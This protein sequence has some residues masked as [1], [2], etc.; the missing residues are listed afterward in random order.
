[1]NRMTW[2]IVGAV[3]AA[4][5]MLGCSSTAPTGRSYAEIRFSPA[6]LDFGA[7]PQGTSVTKEL[8]ITDSGSLALTLSATTVQG[9]VRH[10]FEVATIPSTIAAGTTVKVSV[11]YHATTAGQDGA[12]IDVV[13]NADNAPSARVQLAGQTT[14][15]PAK[16]GQDA[17]GSIP[18]GC[19]GTLECGNCSDG[20]VCLQNT[21]AA[22]TCT[23]GVKDGSETDVDCG[24]SQCPACAATKGCA[25]PSDCASGV[26]QDG[27]CQAPT[28]TD[29]VKNGD[30]TGVDCGGSC[31]KACPDGQGCQKN[32]DCTSGVCTSGICQAPT[33]TDGVKNGAETDVDCGGSACPPC[34]ATKACAKPSDCASG[35]CTN[36]I[37]QAPTCTDG[38]QNGDETGVDCG[39]SCPSPCVDGEGCMHNSDCV[40]GVCDNGKCQAP[41]CTDGVKNGA[42]TDVDCGGSKCPAC[43]AG[44]ACSKPSDCASG[45]CTNGICQAPT[46]TDGVKN[47]DETDTDCGGATCPACAATKGCAK[48]SDCASGVCTTGVC[49]AP[50]CTDGVENGDETGVDCGGSCPTPCADGGG[51]KQASDCASGVCTGGICQAPTCTDQVKNG[52]ETGVDCGG[53]CPA[54]PIGQGCQHGSDCTTASCVSNVCACTSDVQCGSGQVCTSTGQC[55]AACKTATDCT[56]S[57]DGQVCNSDTGHCTSTCSVDAD[58]GTGNYCEPSNGRCYAKCQTDADCPS[59]EACLTG[60]SVPPTL[61]N[62]C[63]FKCASD[64][65]CRPGERCGFDNPRFCEPGTNINLSTSNQDGL[66]L[67]ISPDTT[68]YVGGLTSAN[69]GV[70]DHFSPT[71]AL[72]SSGTLTASSSTNGVVGLALDSAGTVYT[73]DGFVLGTFDA[74]LSSAW[75][76][77][78]TVGVVGPEQI[79]F[80]PSGALDIA[81]SGNGLIKQVRWMGTHMVTATIGDGLDRP[82]QAVAVDAQRRLFIA[83]K[84]GAG[85]LNGTWG[86]AR[87]GAGFDASYASDPTMG[88][89]KSMVFD[90]AGD[91]FVTDEPDGV[92][93]KITPR[94][95]VI[96]FADGL[97]QPWGLAFDPVGRLWVTNFGK[98]VLTVFD[99]SQ[100]APPAILAISPTSGRPGDTLTI[101]GTNFDATAGAKNNTVVFWN[102]Y[103][104]VRVAAGSSAG[105]IKLPI[106]TGLVSDSSHPIH[107]AVVTPKGTGISAQTLTLTACVDDLL[108]NHC[109][110]ACDND[111]DCN[112]GQSCR[113]AD[114]SCQTTCTS[115]SCGSG[116]ACDST[117]GA[118]LAL[119]QTDADCPPLAHC[120][121]DGTC[122][123]Y[124]HVDTDCAVG[125][126]CQTTTGACTDRCATGADC[127]SGQTC[128]LA[129]GGV[130]VSALCATDADC[131]GASAGPKC[132]AATGQCGPAC[133]SASDCKQN[134][135]CD[136]TTHTCLNCAACP[137]YTSCQ[138]STSAC[139]AT[140]SYDIDCPQGQRCATYADGSSY[141]VPGEVISVV[142]PS[143]TALATSPEG[144]I[145]AGVNPS[146]IAKVDPATGCIV[147]STG[148]GGTV[149]GLAIGSDGNVYATNGASLSSYAP[150]LTGAT[151]LFGNPDVQS[152]W[153]IGFDPTSGKLDVSSTGNAVIKQVTFISPPL[154]QTFAYGLGLTPGALAVRSDGTALVAGT[155]GA[156]GANLIVQVDGNSGT[157]SPYATMPATANTQGMAIDSADSLYVSDADNDVVYLVPKGGGSDS[158][159][160]DG[161]S[162]PAGV[163]VDPN[164]N[165]L[166]G[167]GSKI[168]RI[169]RTPSAPHITFITP[170]QGKAGDTVDIY[171]S[172]FAPKASDNTV[173]FGSNTSG[174]WV[175]AT[176]T[177]S[178]VQQLEVQLPSGLPT[179]SDGMTQV[180]VTTPK[181]TTLADQL[182]CGGS[183]CPPPATQSCRAGIAPN[184][185]AFTNVTLPD[186]GL[187]VASNTLTLTGFNAPIPVSISGDG[188]PQ[189]QVGSGPWSTNGTLA[190]GQTLTVRLTSSTT[191]ATLNA[192]IIAGTTSSTWTV[193]TDPV[194]RLGISPIDVQYDGTNSVTVT[195]HDAND[196]PIAYRAGTVSGD[197]TDE[198]CTD[199]CP[200][201]FS[202]AAGQTSVTDTHWFNSGWVH[203]SATLPNG[204]K[205]SDGCS[206]WSCP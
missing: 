159:M 133:A 113:P 56:G 202:M 203:A 86:V 182:F 160:T 204:T 185:F 7:Q 10:A 141:C 64:G 106:P 129:K 146:S 196:H 3:C 102:K 11:T 178:S 41:T 188:S 50:T 140:C 103:S 137:E 192:S 48:P 35:V 145:Y 155:K 130:C 20:N 144:W 154:I 122:T 109:A 180:R 47:G 181:G 5:G 150:D 57:A 33:C 120:G 127:A 46:C 166:I 21:C 96:R 206:G 52:D 70:V 76:Q 55:V 82:P 100:N 97:Y 81:S 54:C 156:T 67:A 173:S 94:G 139:E 184:A 88:D 176:I 108:T 66:G 147:T 63:V 165:V 92:L 157:V 15:T 143:A 171:G 9:D 17:C 23:D 158:V 95:Q 44:E 36:G 45:V 121:A 119:C 138:A 187:V 98:N 167:S 39:G 80:E 84:I 164:Q 71:G 74:A 200:L 26:C 60:S 69:A 13:S 110:V 186:T 199:G 32:S 135:Y 18:D 59:G 6:T 126:Y 149:R 116:Q 131:A 177:A 101:V 1:M 111:L 30:E 201:P 79:Q 91:L 83:G 117:L 24:G 191:A 99:I 29:G 85:P 22:P 12:Y 205:V 189:L 151:S 198:S 190:P 78:Q 194:V 75:T 89:L 125:Q 148:A 169:D 172:N 132:D 87:V 8:A 68:V 14:C 170:T 115:G 25:K 61:Q 183:S 163:A 153:G 197:I 43:S 123:S 40:S 162:S 37:C 77:L 31:P 152:P 27:V 174:T 2:R 179:A 175:D 42:E 128:D 51:C 72:I 90:A 114:N 136:A 195:L 62:H 105:Q 65:D 38:V 34:A 104:T 118:C 168:V 107:V 161:L 19:G 124:C 4:I 93:W 112:N 73:S 28:C 134:Y 142:T 58:C 193:T 53:S 49:Q 16:C